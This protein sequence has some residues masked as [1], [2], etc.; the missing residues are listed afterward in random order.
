MLK[1]LYRYFV[2]CM[3]RRRWV[4]ETKEIIQFIGLPST[5]KEFRADGKIL[6]IAPHADDELIGCHQI[7][8]HYTNNVTVFYCS[9]LGSNHDESNRVIREN[10]I[11]EFTKHKNVD[12]VTSC[13]S[14]VPR[15][16]VDIIRALQP[17][18]I[19]LPSIVD[20]HPE[21]RLVNTKLADIINVCPDT[22]GWYHVSMPIPREYINAYC[23]MTTE[24]L[25]TKWSEMR[26]FYHSQLH[27]DLER[28]ILVERLTGKKET[29]IESY[30]LLS[31]DDFVRKVENSRFYEKELNSLKST[32]GNLNFMYDKTLKIYNAI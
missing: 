12:L 28:F 4:K 32:L 1:K 5:A 24:Q 22:I 11:R 14:N 23:S 31:K 8:S 13:P 15:D 7:I 26:T 27:M 19:F 2:N 20:W 25:M 30:L 17:E 6:V 10:E 29:A 18:I 3:K 9:Y 16:L 21:H